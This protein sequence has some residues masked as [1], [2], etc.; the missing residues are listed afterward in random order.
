MVFRGKTNFTS[1]LSHFKD[2]FNVLVVIVEGENILN[3]NKAAD[4]V[5]L[6]CFQKRSLL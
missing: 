2:S 3:P 6:T 1:I 5:N 4:Q